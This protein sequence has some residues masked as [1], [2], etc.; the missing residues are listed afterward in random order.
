ML[1][2]DR[3][4]ALSR[5]LFVSGEVAELGERSWALREDQYAI[6]CLRDGLLEYRDVLAAFV[7]LTKQLCSCRLCPNA[8]DAATSTGGD[9]LNEEGSKALLAGP[10]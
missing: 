10:R 8:C 1:C 6:D 2:S 9:M 5:N 3:D 4:K 7:N